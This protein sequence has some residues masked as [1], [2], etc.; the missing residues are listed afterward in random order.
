LSDNFDRI[1]EELKSSYDTIIID[2]PPVGLVSDGVQVL[3]M[4]DV[5]IYVFKANYS[6]RHFMGRVDELVSVQGIKNLNLI[7]NGVKIGR[8]GYGYGYGY[9][10]GG[11]YEEQ[12]KKK[13]FNF[14]KKKA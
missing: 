2:N 13:R 5:P 3:A 7:L 12:V 10:Y 11:Y 14:F 4:A 6:K 8:K 1:I 9:G